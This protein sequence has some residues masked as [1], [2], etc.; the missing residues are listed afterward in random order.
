MEGL[1]FAVE[2][3]SSASNPLARMEWTDTGAGSYSPEAI[4]LE[5]RA[6]RES[7]RVLTSNLQN[8]KFQPNIVCA[9][10]AKYKTVFKLMGPTTFAGNNF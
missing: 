5:S 3:F 2:D 1:N 9:S 8:F 7:V 6:N 10:K 4:P